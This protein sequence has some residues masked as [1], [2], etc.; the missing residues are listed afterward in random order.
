MQTDYSIHESILYPM[1]YTRIFFG[2]LK[3]F[4]LNT[5]SMVKRFVF[6]E[7]NQDRT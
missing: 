4:S 3:F 7:R 1:K 2:R 5:Y 6:R